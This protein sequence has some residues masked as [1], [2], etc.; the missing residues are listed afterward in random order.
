MSEEREDPLVQSAT[1]PY[2]HDASVAAKILWSRFSEAEF[3]KTHIIASR[4]DFMGN[5]H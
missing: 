3:L 1:A 4:N 5:L 2:E